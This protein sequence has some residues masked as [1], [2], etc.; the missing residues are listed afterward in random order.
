MS[1]TLAST[2]VLVGCIGAASA[3]PP[4]ARVG[5][6][7][8][9]AV[10][11][12]GVIVRQG[13][14]WT[15]LIDGW[16]FGRGDTSAGRQQLE[17]QLTVQIEDID[18]ACTLTDP[19]RKKLQLAGRGDIK[20]FFDRY[21]QLLRK[22]Q[23]VEHNERNLQEMQRE[24][25]QLRRCLH[26]G[27]FLEHSLFVKSLPNTLTNEQLARYEA[28]ALKGRALRHY[29]S[30]LEAVAFLKRSFEASVAARRLDIVLREEQRQHLITLM[31]HETKPSRQPSQY[32]VQVLLLQFSDLPE[33]KLKR[34]FDDDQW[35]IVK[36]IKDRYQ[37]PLELRL[38]GL[39]RDEVDSTA[40]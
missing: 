27:L 30:V 12:N 13:R 36:G 28:K 32:D 2:L 5:Q 23:M 19:Q 16:V 8:P 40:K 11:V 14:A 21:E 39:L 37:R 29:E 34:L 22:S 35:E 3:Q 31:T 1:R 25:N 24:A 17:W 7:V 4:H 10:L 38:Q 18:R 33:E 20:R 6:A 9:P 15:D 26:N